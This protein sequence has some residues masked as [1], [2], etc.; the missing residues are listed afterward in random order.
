[1]QLTTSTIR[2]IERANERFDR[3]IRTQQYA[4]SFAAMGNLEEGRIFAEAAREQMRQLRR[5]IFTYRYTVN[6]AAVYKACKHMIGH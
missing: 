1:M 5:Y 4:Q 2:T 3:Y 6:N